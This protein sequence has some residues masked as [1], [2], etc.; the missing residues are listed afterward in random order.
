MIGEAVGRVESGVHA[1]RERV[2]FA[3]DS[4]GPRGWF[5]LIGG[6]GVC[7]FGLVA[8]FAPV[9]APFAPDTRVGQPF[10]SPDVT[11]LLGTDDVGRDVLSLLLV[12]S[13]VSLL[14]GLL[15]GS[16]AILI[17]I[18]VG[19]TAGLL[20][21]K[22]ETLAMR[23]VDVVLTLPF[24]PL[25]IV[26]AAILGPSLWTTVAVL[27]SVMWARP[28][29]E[30]RSEILSVRER[31]YVRASRGMGASYPH[32]A[33]N[34][35]V[36]AVLPI[37]IAQFAKAVGAA[38]LL[39]ASLSFLGLGD[40]TAPSW[41][42]ILFYAQSRSAFLTDAWTWWVLPPGVAITACV[43]SFTFLAL[44]VE[45]KSGG[46]RRR[47]ASDADSADVEIAQS[48]PAALSVSDLTVEYADAPETAA[49]D[50]VDL[51]LREDEVLGIV[52]ESGS[53]KSS[54]ALALL[55]L[56][57]TPG[58]VTSGR[59]T[60]STEREYDSDVG[61]C[62]VRGDEI[63]FVPQEAMN[64][65][66]PRITLSE[67]VVEAIRTHQSPG[68]DAA[69]EMAREMLETVGLDS[70]SHD[71]YPHELSGGMRQRGVIAIALVNDPS[72]LVVDEP[73]TG[74]DVV[75]KL[76]VLEILEE[77]QKEG[78][79]SLVLVSHDLSVV[80]RVADRLA[81]MRD[82][83]FVERGRA[84]RLQ[85]E[86]ETQYTEELLTART[87]LPV[88]DRSA[89]A[90][91]DPEA[92]DPE[93]ET[94]VSDGP[95]PAATTDA[96]PHLAYEGVSKTF[97]GGE[98]VLS[99][100]DL[101]VDRGESV[102]LLG[103]SGAGKSTLGRMAAGFTAP[104]G[105][106]VRI[107]G[108]TV[109]RWQE[110]DST[111]LGRTVH[112]LFQDPY[113]S[114]PPDRSVE[115]IVR[116]PLDIHDIGASSARHERVQE[117]LTDVGLAPADEYA[118]RYPTELSGGERQRVALARAVVLEPSVLV[119]DEPASMLDAPL[120]DELLTLLYELV[121][122]RGITLLHVTHD[123]ARASSFADRIAVLHEGR[124]VEEGSP[125]SIL[126]NTD[127]EQTRMLVDAVVELTGDSIDDRPHSTVCD[128]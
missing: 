51:E 59:I 103:E 18:A 109:R 120:Q 61:L 14:V 116:E 85:S 108:E 20:G 112:Y 43:L 96:D 102:A 75:T 30:L 46:D 47:V 79:F 92:T 31:E 36:P 29:R 70:T 104:D 5:L 125:E 100:V 45:R 23:I 2:P 76:H 99:G 17:G 117:A 24:L 7:I 16:V 41:G 52:G 33:V 35:V 28:A 11:H 42:T 12:G 66:D 72:V 13:R 4:D 49:V 115:W 15:T 1:F 58:R 122:D 60:L 93:A 27:T 88:T 63:G 118:D 34:Y 39:E 32:V 48:A 22:V 71:Q 123:V 8:L 98:E 67:Q 86:P 25:V 57:R 56:L 37:A 53:G 91:D 101:C 65:L 97:G 82:G 107:A 19:T 119:A 77:L 9:L 80:T 127:H 54:L 105:G 89:D 106:T 68:R 44:G 111:R 126:R 38:V 78:E 87:E 128:Q 6:T 81:V 94:L 95:E 84:D 124:I 10:Q 50:D 90:V 40:P 64:A 3:G 62:D 74:L 114:I 121:A 69:A 55:G 26:A 110:R 113:G 21:G 83:S 73:T